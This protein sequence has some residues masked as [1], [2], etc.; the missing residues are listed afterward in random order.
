MRVNLTQDELSSVFDSTELDFDLHILYKILDKLP[1]V[2]YNRIIA[3]E[4][5][6]N[7]R[8]E[9]YWALLDT[10]TGEVRRF[11]TRKSLI[12]YCESNNIASYDTVSRGLKSGKKTGKGYVFKKVLP[13]DN[14]VSSE[15]VDSD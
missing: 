1:T 13:T 5:F 11:I 15:V 7:V 3:D 2:Y 8:G 14:D 9:P 6:I 10:N 12:D 4:Y